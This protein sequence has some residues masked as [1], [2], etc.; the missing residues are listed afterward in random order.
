MTD[1]FLIKSQNCQ[2]KV[3]QKQKCLKK[4][5]TGKIQ[6]NVQIWEKTQKN[7]NK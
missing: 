4:K 7:H 2:Q 6:K 1:Y 5:T 3:V